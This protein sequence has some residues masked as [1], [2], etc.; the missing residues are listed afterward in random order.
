MEHQEKDSIIGC[1]PLLFFIES[2][3]NDSKILENIRRNDR[4]YKHQFKL[5]FIYW[6]EE[7]FYD[8]NLWLTTKG[9]EPL[10]FIES[11]ENNKKWEMFYNA[12][13]KNIS[14]SAYYKL[15]LDGF[16]DRYT[17]EKV[18][19]WLLSKEYDPIDAMEKTSVKEK[20]MQWELYFKRGRKSDETMMTFLKDIMHD[21]THQ[22][23]HIILT[24]PLHVELWKAMFHDC[25]FMGMPSINDWLMRNGFDPLCEC[26][27]DFIENPTRKIEKLA[28]KLQKRFGEK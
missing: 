25:V 17:T 13:I 26:R 7:E 10:N 28:A 24:T 8:V 27:Y 16:W 5:M 3:S 19:V 22:C 6:F 20:S 12:M 15:R 9:Y 4:F 23:G 11:N 21:V 18:N 14:L 1:D 2:V